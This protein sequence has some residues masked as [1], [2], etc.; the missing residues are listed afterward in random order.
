MSLWTI[1]GDVQ[2]SRVTRGAV[3]DPR[4]DL[5]QGKVGKSLFDTEFERP[6]RI[7]EVPSRA[8]KTNS[9]EGE[10]LPE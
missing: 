9:K 6:K 2:V 1:V 7:V 4:P 10:D 5:S 3:G 8:R